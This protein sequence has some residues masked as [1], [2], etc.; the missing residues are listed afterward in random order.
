[1][2]RERGGN[3][4]TKGDG[5]YI[6]LA[7][8]FERRFAAFR[9]MRRRRNRLFYVATSSRGGGALRLTNFLDMSVLLSGFAHQKIQL[10]GLMVFLPFAPKSVLA[11]GAA[12]I[13]SKR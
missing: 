1:M 11:T 2:E 5:R 6:G 4:G 13:Q 12:P 7:R 10:A 8:E 9:D 3:E